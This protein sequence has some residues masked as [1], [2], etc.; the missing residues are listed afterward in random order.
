[1]ILQLNPPPGAI[2]SRP[3][4]GVLSSRSSGSLLELQ[5]VLDAIERDAAQAC[6]AKKGG[7]A[8]AAEKTV[9]VSSAGRGAAEDAAP[10]APAALRAACSLAVLVA[11]VSLPAAARAFRAWAAGSLTVDVPL[12]ALARL[13]LSPAGLAVFR[14]LPTVTGALTLARACCCMTLVS[15]VGAALAAVGVHRR[16]AW[17]VAV[18]AVP[19]LAAYALAGGD[20]YATICTNLSTAMLVWKAFSA[21]RGTPAPHHRN[22][23]QSLVLY[24]ASPVPVLPDA[25]NADLAARLPL[26]SGEV[27]RRAKSIV[28]KC[29]C[30]S[31]LLSL[32]IGAAPTT[33]AAAPLRTYA[34]VWLVYLSISSTTEGT[35]LALRIAGWSPR[36]CFRSPLAR[37]ESP[38][39]MWSRRWNLGVRDL[40]F[41]TVY[42]PLRNGC[43]A[44]HWLA[45][46]ATFLASGLLHEAMI[47][48][49]SRKSH[50]GA[51]LLFFASQFPFVVAWRPL[52]ERPLLSRL[53]PRLRTAL[54]V[55]LTNLALLP[56]APLFVDSLIDAGMFRS[57]ST[58][59][60]CLV[61]GPN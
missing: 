19:T 59:L 41:E 27:A 24:V 46:L 32:G 34:A 58:I 12:T 28:A 20:G 9:A 55:S 17:L 54:G 53:P 2:E 22:S 7:H 47:A 18:S 21:W 48:R 35:C 26:R 14:V 25:A 51:Q 8:A 10:R 13:G 4:T 16:S 37:S 56:L 1:M 31:V 49:T 60:P 40:F 43:G 50:R 45:S 39:D 61:V 23:L 29:V 42:G 57:L 30:M 15:C 5:A 6:A 3:S 36:E 33:W 38:Y 11:A 44:P 52:V